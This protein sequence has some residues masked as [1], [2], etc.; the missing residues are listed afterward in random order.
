MA[1]QLFPAP[2]QTLFTFDG[3]QPFLG[4][5]YRSDGL[6]MEKHSLK[7]VFHLGYIYHSLQ[8]HG[9]HFTGQTT[10]ALTKTSQTS[11]SYHRHHHTQSSGKDNRTKINYMG[12]NK[13]LNVIIMFMTFGVTYYWLPLFLGIKVFSSSY[14]RLT[15]VW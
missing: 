8:D 4:T 13:L 7:C 5:C 15:T 14:L 2:G 1:T 9:T 6:T 12:L 10:Q 3:L 11:Y